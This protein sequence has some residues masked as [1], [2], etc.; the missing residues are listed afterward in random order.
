MQSSG[1]M[2]FLRVLE[3]ISDERQLFF[4][5]RKWFYHN[6][7]LILFLAVIAAAS[8]L[9]FYQAR[10]IPFTHDEWSAIFRTQ[11]P[12]IQTLIQKGVMPDGHPAGIQI[13]LY[14]LVRLFGI[15]ALLIKLPFMIFGVLSVILV[16]Q[17]A[18]KLFGITNALISA[19]LMAG[20][21]YTIMYSQ[22]ARPYVSG[23]FFGL[24]LVYFWIG[25]IREEKYRWVHYSGF[26][27][28]GAMCMYNHYFSALFFLLVGLSGAFFIKGRPLFKLSGAVLFT[29]LLFIP[30]THLTLNHLEIAGLD[31]WLATPGPGFIWQY[32]AYA[33]H[34]S[35][36]LIL[37]LAG[38]WILG[39]LQ[40]MRNRPRVNPWALLFASWF[41]ASFLIGFLYSRMVEPVLQYSVLI[42]T[43]PFLVMALFSHLHFNAFR[44]RLLVVAMTFAL[45]VP[46]LT[47]KRQY[48]QLFYNSRYTEIPDL[49]KQEEALSGNE[50]SYICMGLPRRIMRH[51]LKPG[52]DI[53]TS[54]VIWMEEVTRPGDL[55]ALLNEKQPAALVYAHEPGPSPEIFSILS[56]HF[57]GLVR[58]E[59]YFLG[60]YHVFSNDSTA[61]RVPSL[62]TSTFGFETPDREWEQVD[63]RHLTDTLRCSGQYAYTFDSDL[64]YGP[65][66][67]HELSRSLVRRNLVADASLSAWVGEEFEDALLVCTLE[68]KGTI[69]EWQASRFRDY[70]TS[71]DRWNR[72]YFSMRFA[73][74]P[75]RAQDLTMK[76]YVWNHEKQNF[77]V[78][79]L[80]IIIRQGN[81]VLYGLFQPIIK[82][83]GIRSFH[84]L[85]E[86]D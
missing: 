78:D 9:R 52:P 58:S 72:I 32:L 27:L 24:L 64:E 75:I 18:R 14:Y 60:N 22:L 76:L 29:L 49:L 3:D 50:P 19:S 67:A 7:E 62:V 47:L 45:T 2:L 4:M 73:D 55:L 63:E 46:T 51:Y 23:L 68:K 43:F 53:D 79:D 1:F 40:P 77:V 6:R 8:L 38:L 33:W 69:I 84:P 85:P 41:M 56:S 57:N 20:L 66:Y 86:K 12:D 80:E 83:S 11:Y 82:F 15:N 59:Y 39:W 71:Y 28:S 26:V 31:E 13:I 10:H 37:F 16:Y 34:Y 81:P 36:L 21:E 70:I 42:F 35:W 17:I 25:I 65:V 44:T 74:L 54:K 5:T 48:Y 30:H 61:R